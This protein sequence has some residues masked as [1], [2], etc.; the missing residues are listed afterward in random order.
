M[1]SNSMVIKKQIIN[2]GKREHPENIVQD[3]KER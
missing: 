1:K 2:T 3:I